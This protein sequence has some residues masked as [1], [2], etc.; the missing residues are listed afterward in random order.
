MRRKIRWLKLTKLYYTIR[1]TVMASPPVKRGVTCKPKYGSGAP[2]VLKKVNEF[3][4]PGAGFQNGDQ[5]GSRA[6]CE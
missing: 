1:K 2:L 6:D 4:A 5:S 3:D